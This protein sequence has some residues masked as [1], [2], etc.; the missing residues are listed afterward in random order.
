MVSTGHFLI[1]QGTT[2]VAAFNPTT[3]QFITA[4]LNQF[5]GTAW[6]DSSF[7]TD[8]SDPDIGVRHFYHN[9][10]YSGSPFASMETSQ[11]VGVRWTVNG[12]YRFR[13]DATGVVIV[14]ALAGVGNRAVYSDSVGTL[15]NS[16]SDERLK[17][18]IWESPY[19]LDA[20][21]E[22]NPVTYRW[23]DKSKGEQTELGFIAQDMQAI[24]PEVI[25][26]N[27]DG[28]LSLDYPKLVAVMAKAIQELTA[29]VEEL[30]NG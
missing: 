9:T 1:Y 7:F 3:V 20:V 19:G 18:S 15:T 11:T 25:G 22:M 21:L 6:C 14:N 23:K 17:E 24:V 26:E 2:Q 13:I 28:M 12:S 5:S 16:A 30:E 27:S 29:R 4:D 8:N 10:V